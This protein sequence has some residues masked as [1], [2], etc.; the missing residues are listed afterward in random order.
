MNH[1]MGDEA[2]P[3]SVTT[4]GYEL[5]RLVGQRFDPTVA[6]G[7][8]LL[9][10][11]DRAGVIE[12]IQSSVLWVQ[13]H[14]VAVAAPGEMPFAHDARPVAGRLEPFSDGETVPRVVINERQLLHSGPWR[15]VPRIK[16]DTKHA[17]AGRVLT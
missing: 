15:S 16:N 13:T 11:D 9:P 17:A 12:S 3:G 1:V 2:K 4:L 6:T 10:R 7:L 14:N 8:K 5:N